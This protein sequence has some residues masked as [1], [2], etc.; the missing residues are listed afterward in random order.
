[1][2][3]VIRVLSNVFNLHSHIKQNSYKYPTDIFSQSS[4]FLYE[5]HIFL[6]K[7]GNQHFTVSS[8]NS[9]VNKNKEKRSGIRNIWYLIGL[10]TKVVTYMSPPVSL[11]KRDLYM[12]ALKPFIN[13]IMFNFIPWWKGHRI[14]ETIFSHLNTHN[15]FRIWSIDEQRNA[16]SCYILHIKK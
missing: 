7:S 9:I 2:E 6:F 15:N 1:M 13:L 5:S 3:F 11:Q 12:W 8:I 14:K 4:T 10:G 16:S